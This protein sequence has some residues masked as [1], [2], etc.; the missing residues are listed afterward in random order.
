LV[1]YGHLLIGVSL[2]FGLMVRIS[3]SFGIVLMLIYWMAHMDW[4]FIE[5][6]NNLILDYHIV[7]A[8]VL[9]YLIVKR[10]GHVFG[11]DGLAERLQFVERH[12]I[13]R[14]LVHGSVKG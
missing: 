11:L 3:A 9:G 5:N 7:Y 8:G 2:V 10:A 12:P 6:K 1:E 4:P 14:P 13:L